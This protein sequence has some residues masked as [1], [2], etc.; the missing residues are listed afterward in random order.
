MSSGSAPSRPVA[1][2]T[3][4]VST[5]RDLSIH[6]MPQ[7]WPPG[8]PEDRRPPAR[9]QRSARSLTASRT[10]PRRGWG[11]SAPFGAVPERHREP[12]RLS[13]GLAMAFSR[14]MHQLRSCPVRVPRCIC[15]AYGS[16]RSSTRRSPL[17]TC[18]DTRRSA[19]RRSAPCLRAAIS[20]PVS[21]WWRSRWRAS[22]TAT[23]ARDPA[24]RRQRTEQG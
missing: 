3:G 16:G 20:H 11:W 9:H 17:V 8:L 21:G 14:I 2:A 22:L 1:A 6:E 23:A 10:E 19:G 12:P 7:G 24:R 18:S 13:P 5:I 4:G 15:A